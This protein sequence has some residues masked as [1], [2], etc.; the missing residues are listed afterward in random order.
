MSGATMGVAIAGAGFISYMH[1]F[2]IR[3]VP[4]LRLRAIASRSRDAAVH[5]GRVF[6]APPYGFDQLAEMIG[7]DDVQAVVIAGP[8]A[9][10]FEHA[11]AAIALKRHVIVEKPLVLTLDECAALERAAR[12]Q[13]VGIGYAENL[14]FA[15]IVVRA[16]ELIAGGIIGRV[17]HAECTFKHG[18]P[19]VGGWFR[20]AP[21]AGG[22]AHIDLGCHALEILLVLLGRPTVAEVRACTMQFDPASGL[23]LTA[24]ATYVT[25]GGVPV[26]TD[27]SWVEP[28]GET[29]C[30]IEGETGVLNVGISSQSLTLE[31]KNGAKE[32]FAFPLQ[33]DFS[34]IASAS[35]GGY[36]A[37]M[38]HFTQAFAR[39]EM[40]S[41][42]VAEGTNILR[43]VAAAYGSAATG[44]PFLP[45]QVP[46]DV[47][48]IGLVTR[49]KR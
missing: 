17:T 14:I 49:F 18:G 13:G 37:Q 43:L 8:N 46:N 26:V 31:H 3:A 45:E 11:M 27:S 16:A 19:P 38:A 1:A 35:R 20:S 22:G 23:D 33:K 39:G 44:A 15:P 21:L 24:H 5:R 32:S 7:R 41:E 6:D 12:E 42:G 29:R 40:P 25:Q 2:A 34:L 9:L 4:G 30:R 47:S 10:H 48:P 28:N 36:V